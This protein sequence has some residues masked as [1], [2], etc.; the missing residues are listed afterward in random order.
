MIK[1]SIL[2]KG[3]WIGITAPSSGVATELHGLLQTRIDS[4]IL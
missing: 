3:A 1:Y 2:E 4:A